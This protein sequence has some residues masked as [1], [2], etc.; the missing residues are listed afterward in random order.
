MTG[1]QFFNW[2]TSGGVD[3]VM[4]LVDGLEKADI[5]WCII[6]GIAVNH[7]AKEPMVTQDLDMVV[8]AADI[9]R[10][11]SLIEKLG[12]KIIRF[13]NE[14][15]EKNLEKVLQELEKALTI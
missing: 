9:E 7:W 6:G 10:A 5:E 15:V 14:D 1:K 2:Q 13:K 11:T 12:F 8:A 4:R 3:D